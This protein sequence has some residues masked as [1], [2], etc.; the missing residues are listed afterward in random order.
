MHVILFHCVPEDVNSMFT[1]E[2]NEM[3][4][5]MYGVAPIVQAIL[6]HSHSQA[7]LH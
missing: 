6:T 7:H 5:Y 3:G 1:E 4:K 2:M